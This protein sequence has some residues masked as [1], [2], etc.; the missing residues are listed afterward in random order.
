MSSRMM[1]GA[2]TLGLQ[3]LAR[4]LG[5][6]QLLPGDLP[7]AEKILTQVPRRSAREQL[8]EINPARGERK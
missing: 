6:T 8:K 4:T 7:Q 1:W 2:Q 5:L 3:K